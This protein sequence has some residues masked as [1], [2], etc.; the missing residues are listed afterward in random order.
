MRLQTV[1]NETNGAGI[2]RTK[3]K[4]SSQWQQRDEDPA[5]VATIVEIEPQTTVVDP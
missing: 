5:K 3:R 4:K 2:A 1:S